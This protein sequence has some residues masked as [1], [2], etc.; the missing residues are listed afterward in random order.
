MPHHCFSHATPSIGGAAAP[1]TYVSDELAA[2]RTPP[3]PIFVCKNEEFVLRGADRFQRAL[4]FVALDGGNSDPV[5]HGDARFRW[6]V[7]A[8]G[9]DEH[10][11]TT[12][13]KGW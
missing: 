8:E 7:G 12:S 6:A 4:L 5:N 11:T 10:A 3:P 2:S 13:G 1:L 9:E